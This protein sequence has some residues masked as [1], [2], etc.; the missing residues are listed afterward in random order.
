MKRGGR[1]KSSYE[2]LHEKAFFHY[3][4]ILLILGAFI[5]SL[6][7]FANTHQLKKI[8]MPKTINANDFLKKLTAHDEM[9]AY[10][11]IA[12]LNIVEINPNNIVNLQAQINELDTTYIGNFI[13]QY[14]DRIAIKFPM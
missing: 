7:A 11:G 8:L 1:L 6:L 9:K 12:P 5:F 2:P 10:M 14:S 3:I 4:V 13:V